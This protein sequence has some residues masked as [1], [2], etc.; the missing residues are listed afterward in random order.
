MSSTLFK[1]RPVV[2]TTATVIAAMM[3][4]AASQS[5]QISPTF[6]N[7][8]GITFPLFTP[9]VPHDQWTVESTTRQEVV[10]PP[11]N[12]VRRWSYRSADT[13]QISSSPGH[14]VF[15][16]TFQ[17]LDYADNG[18]NFEYAELGITVPPVSCIHLPLPFTCLP[19]FSL[20]FGPPGTG[21]PVTDTTAASSHYQAV[22][23]RNQSS[24][25]FTVNTST[26]TFDLGLSFTVPFLS[27]PMSSLM[28]L[29][30]TLGATTTTAINSLLAVNWPSVI[31]IGVAILCATLLLPQLATWLASLTSGA[32]GG[33]SYTN[34]YGRNIDR[35][36]SLLPVAP[37]TAILSQLDDALAQYDLDSTSCMQRAVC[38]YV[39]ESELSIKKGDADSNEMIVA[40]LARS[41]WLQ[42]LLGK[43]SL[44]KA[45]EMGRSGAN[46]QLQYPKCPFSL[47]GVLR[48]LATYSSLTS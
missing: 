28:N 19:A 34:S 42:A 6:G 26:Q 21:I 45:V 39:A 16:N 27:I 35:E 11:P 1:V 48:F 5:L 14:N 15:T 9:S 40:G 30:D 43:T 25:F 18:T 4:L 7:G 38:T 20:L 46:C 29:G 23:S 12:Q 41:T 2:V 10:A 17:P 36:G 33:T 44:T 22:G 32:G 47:A 24:R 31:F 8:G 37:F 3:Q 13:G